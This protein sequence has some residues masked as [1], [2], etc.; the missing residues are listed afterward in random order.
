MQVITDEASGLT[1]E[2]IEPGSASDPFTANPR[3]S[4]ASPAPVNPLAQTADGSKI[5]TLQPTSAVPATPAPA[6]TAVPVA[7]V[8]PAAPAVPAAELSP[9]QVAINEGRLDEYIAGLVQENTGRALRT[10]QSSY[11]KQIDALRKDLE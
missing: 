10:Q 6:S 9:M 3:T 4:A 5:A 7:P 8:V 1:F 2:V 11:D